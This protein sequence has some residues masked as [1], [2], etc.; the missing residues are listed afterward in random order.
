MSQYRQRAAP[1]P[2]VTA[3]PV[4]TTIQYGTSGAPEQTIA[5]I[6]PMIQLADELSSS[7]GGLSDS[8]TGL[9]FSWKRLQGK[10]EQA[11]YDKFKELA[12]QLNMNNESIAKLVEAGEAH[13]SE[14]PYILK[15]RSRAYGEALAREFQTKT[16]AIIPEMRMTNSAFGDTEGALNWFSAESAS[17]MRSMPNAGGD[18][19]ATM[20]AFNNGVNNYRERF[21]VDQ[22]R[23]VGEK[24]LEEATLGFTVGIK[25]RVKS[26]YSMMQ[27]AASSQPRMMTRSAAAAMGNTRE[28][29]LESIKRGLIDQTSG[30]INDDAT[31]F[32]PDKW[33]L[34]YSAKNRLTVDALIELAEQEPEYAALA[35]EVLKK[36]QTGPKNNRSPLYGPYAK[37]RLG[38]AQKRIDSNIAHTNRGGMTA[39]EALANVVVSTV[40][41][42]S[43]SSAVSL[44]KA[45]PAAGMMR[46]NLIDTNGTGLIYES[47]VDSLPEGF[48]V[49]Q[50]YRKG[51][52]G[53]WTVDIRSSDSEL[54]PSQRTKSVSLSE[55][56]ARA[57]SKSRSAEKQ[58]FMDQGATEHAAIAKVANG[59]GNITRAE[60]QLFTSGLKIN[61]Q[62]REQVRIL[63]AIND[64]RKLTE[65][66]QV[67]YESMRTAW[68]TNFE[69]TFEGLSLMTPSLRSQVFKND[70]E[71]RMLYTV[72]QSMATGEDKVT[73]EQAASVIADFRGRAGY[74]AM[75]AEGYSRI[76]SYFTNTDGEGVD[77]RDT[78]LKPYSEFDRVRLRDM[79]HAR[80][81]L[82]QSRGRP[83]TPEEALTRVIKEYEKDTEKMGNRR[84]PAD[85]LPPQET[86]PVARVLVNES[87]SGDPGVIVTA[88]LE[89]RLN[90][91]IPEDVQANLLNLKELGVSIEYL[92]DVGDGKNI[93]I[94][95]GDS[96]G[97]IEP[98]SIADF[99]AAE[100]GE[101]LSRYE[102]MGAGDETDN[103]FI[104]YRMDMGILK[105]GIE[106]RGNTSVFDYDPRKDPNGLDGQ[107]VEYINRFVDVEAKSPEQ[108][109]KIFVETKAKLKAQMKILIEEL[110]KSRTGP[111]D[112]DLYDEAIEALENW[113]TPKVPTA[114]DYYEMKLLPTDPAKARDEARGLRSVGPGA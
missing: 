74:Q 6:D 54:Q 19:N 73:V 57:I 21:K 95:I 50:P 66:E 46:Q 113:M 114:G 101:L 64:G 9:A 111:E 68:V 105:P 45:G 110:Q 94:V 87:S 32:G 48:S 107:T 22:Q 80:Y 4:D 27:S 71:A 102:A 99:L 38:E 108:L 51:E 25:D 83:T 10:Q 3:A 53:G 106:F 2:Q 13:P 100:S 91:L 20:K 65:E 43:D 34:T 39:S 79:A 56:E 7:F 15:G 55:I 104:G 112:G 96:A 69:S 77:A 29:A 72:A 28:E 30:A 70:A 24:A 33:P 98:F 42:I 63:E 58:T 88:L 41:V 49:S 82:D 1:T 103:V 78:L 86:L 60:A 76:R 26:A 8:L 81:V 89:G 84:Y 75:V 62:S 93:Q 92:P 14:N 67:M 5:P 90:A 97:D 35:V 12:E 40:D 17:F 31:A 44:F 16:D 11:G 85:R 52:D 59:H 109:E 47:I 23:Y 37:Q 36:V 18:M 61:P